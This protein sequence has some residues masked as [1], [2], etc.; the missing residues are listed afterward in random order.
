MASLYDRYIL[1][2][3]L[4]CACSSSPV[5]KQRA[6]VVPKAQGRV[7]ELGIG[8]G[9]NLSLYDA[10]KVES[11]TGVDPAA[12]LRTIAEAAPR[13]PRLAVKVEDGTAEALPFDAAS[14]DCVVCT[15]T[16]CS[17]HTP[18]AALGEARRVLKPGGRFLYCEHGLAPDPDVAKW[19]RRI[20]PVWKAIAG[21]C[22]LTRPVTA[23]VE[24]AGF[25]VERRDSMYIPGTPRFAGWSEWGE[26]AP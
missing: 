5:M 9:L 12:E 18:A 16:L 22:H 21:G 14:F 25:K 2:K 8:M 19:Q 10:D 7:L 15:F 13:D 24:A 17:V 20:E 1:P 4:K 23:A 11:V 3:F 26:A 6:K